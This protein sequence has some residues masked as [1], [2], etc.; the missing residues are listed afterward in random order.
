MYHLRK[1]FFKYLVPAR[2]ID[3]YGSQVNYKALFTET[4]GNGIVPIYGVAVPHPQN[5]LLP[6]GQNQ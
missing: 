1:I 5:M 3:Y 2:Q 4:K 6:E